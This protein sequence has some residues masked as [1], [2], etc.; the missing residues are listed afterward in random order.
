MIR[1]FFK[2]GI[3]FMMKNKAF[4][5]INIGGLGLSMAVCLLVIML[6]RDA[7]D[8]DH[9]HPGSD[10][11]YRINTEALRKRGGS[12]PYASSP[13]LVGATLASNF[14][15]LEAWTMFNAGMEKDGTVGDRTFRLNM[16][17]TNSEFFHLFGFTFREGDPGT[18][19]NEPH[20]IVLTN[21]LSEKLFPGGDAFGKTISIHGAGLFKV[22]GVLNR[23]PG[24]THFEFEALGSFATIPSLEKDST[25]QQITG[26]WQNYYSNYTYIRLQPGIKSSQVDKALAEIAKKNYKD[27]PLESR[28]AG[29][30][31]YL[32]PLNSITPGPLLSNNMGKALSSG[33]LW[34]FAVLAFIIILSATF[35]YTNLTIAKAMS[36]MKEIALRK[37]VGSSR[38]H[39]FLQ[40]IL[41]SVITS[42]LALVVAFILLQF[43]IPRF[44]NLGFIH[45]AD[46]NFKIDAAL[47]VLFIVFAVALGLLA[48]LLPS[49][50]LS[51]IRP[52]ML[53]Q[54]LQNLKLFRHLGL[55]KG[56][57]VVQFM[58][59]L[60]FIMM[61]TIT[62]RQLG[63]AVN[64]NFGTKQTH[65]FNIQLQGLDH[66]KVVQ[67]FSKIPGVGKISAIS[68]LMGNYT[69]WADDVRI[70]KEKDPVVVREY[71]TDANYIPNLK[72]KLVAGEN[73]PDE[74][75][76]K[77]ERFAI[78]NETFVKNFQL[79][80]PMDAIGKTIMVG[81]TTVLTILGVLK[82]FLFKPANYALEPMFMRYQPAK[83][84]ILN[85]SIASAN[86][87]QSISQL[88]TAWKK[89]DPN[90]PF[91]GKFYDEEIQSIYSDMRDMIWMVAFISFLGIT[92]ACL[93]LLGI[94]L[95]SIQLKIKEISIRKVI[96]ASPASLV[97]L[98]SK[99]YVQVMAIAIAL[100]IPV[101]IL[102]GKRLL[103]EMSQRIALGIGLF[104]PGI[105][106]IVL[107][108]AL[109]ISSQTLRAALLNPVKGLREE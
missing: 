58:I 99:S 67:E 75:A 50:L 87:M 12:E 53:M 103:G 68:N 65:I 44:A 46:I 106:T 41:E 77:L 13:Y 57:L 95:F 30:R 108:S 22:T 54:K 2:T 93:G 74:P 32:Q 90:H 76:Q 29:Y 48:G 88:K 80:S 45:M 61:V 27:I 51:R 18:A 11:I 3:R 52:L 73:F 19:L 70:N 17:F 78:V 101:T 81:D 55:R 33:R 85:L 94:T 79:G 64:V 66:N 20:A 31:F 89:L 72:L 104:L 26:N 92:I 56:L 102:L 60:V 9:F 42:L 86:T 25:I 15:G 23:F 100:A 109:T 39:I 35:N 7:S 16:H 6:I 71:F 8:Y 10:R 69:D 49:I 5:F 4:S 38:W 36:R 62:Y 84:A 40:V 1:N 24:K 47:I 59:S 96:G 98:L 105:I 43:L 28:D 63:Y 21:E 14:T 37:V 91:Q 107:L 83:W 34:F 82:D 97:R